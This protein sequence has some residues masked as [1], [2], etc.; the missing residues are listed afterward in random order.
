MNTSFGSWAMVLILYALP[1]LGQANETLRLLQGE[2]QE[3]QRRQL[4]QRLRQLQRAPTPT[5]TPETD[6]PAPAAAPQCWRPAG[7]SLSG[8]QRIAAPAIVAVVKPLLRAC[9]GSAE[10]NAVLRAIT[11]LYLD[12]G[13]PT[14]RPYLA[15]QPADGEPL[16]IL[17]V[18]GFVEAIEVSAADLPLSLA[19]AFPGLLGEPLQLRQ[20]EQGMDQ[21]NRLRAFDLGVDIEPGE[22]EGGSRLLLSP[23]SRPSRW[24]LGARLDDRGNPATG[25][26]L[27]HFSLGLDSPLQRNDHFGLN[28]TH[29][30]P[31]GRA[32]KRA[33][34]V[35]YQLPYGPWSLA[36]SSSR[37]DHRAPLGQRRGA[38]LGRSGAHAIKLE[39]TL[40][41]N[42]RGL[43][44]GHLQAS[45]KRYD[46]EIS[47]FYTWVQAARVDSLEAGLGAMWLDQGVWTA[48]LSYARGLGP[49]KQPHRGA[50][51]P[52][53]EKYRAS[54]GRHR[55]GQWLGQPWQLNSQLDIQY[56]PNLLPALE[57]LLLTDNGAVRGFRQVAVS[58][59]NGA[60]WHSSLSL[61]R[62]LGHGV[63]LTAQLGLDLGWAH[64]P[65]HFGAPHGSRQRL[66]GASLGASL[67]WRQA[68]LALDYQ[69]ALHDSATTRLEPGFWSSEWSV[70]F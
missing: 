49:G 8:N 33:V 56:S 65:A 64:H 39:R 34:S 4:D 17:I 3:Q 35:S 2:R 38:A 13:Y 68:R 14:S 19:H 69:R 22:R 70:A 37:Q 28:L 18:E 9:M 29:S 6:A 48:G 47:D 54:L 10:I 26:R 46:S 55:A 32:Y 12:A 16:E 66:A 50:P 23:R 63:S 7:L 20:L 21:L 24:Q 62:P 5:P 57:H 45:H 60:F 59:G 58:V 25:R 11:A 31:Q 61:P 67:Q 52:A 36:V 43:L 30:L 44:G 1:G 42:G 27:G 53:F 41:R 40:W 51:Q 15:R